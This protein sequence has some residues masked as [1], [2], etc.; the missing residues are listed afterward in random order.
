MKRGSSLNVK[1]SPVPCSQRSRSKVLKEWMGIELV[2][3]SSSVRVR[4]S[5]KTPPLGP[6]ERWE[7]T[8]SEALREAGARA[9]EPA[10]VTERAGSFLQDLRAG[11]AS[12][13]SVLSFASYSHPPPPPQRSMAGRPFMPLTAMFLT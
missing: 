11:V 4:R 13:F 10:N 2:L 9:M 8:S 3:F 6:L 7:A 12:I 1:C 5:Q